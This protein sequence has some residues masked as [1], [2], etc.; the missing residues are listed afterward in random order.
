MFLINVALV[1]L[2]LRPRSEFVADAENWGFNSHETREIA[3]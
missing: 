1:P 3:R 2:P